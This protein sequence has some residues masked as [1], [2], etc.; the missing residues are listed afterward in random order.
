MQADGFQPALAQCPSLVD[1]DC[2]GVLRGEGHGVVAFFT[3]IPELRARVSIRG[4]GCELVCEL[5]SQA[6]FPSDASTTTGVDRYAAE[7]S[8][9]EFRYL[10]VTRLHPE[11]GGV[12]L[13]ASVPQRLVGA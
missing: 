2:Q 4:V 7:T 6:Y 11:E 12:S 5:S 3:V 8:F 10:L 1:T 9:R 13:K